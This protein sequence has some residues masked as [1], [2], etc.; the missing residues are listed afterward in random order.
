MNRR[1][2][3]GLEKPG[4]GSSEE[5]EKTT[6]NMSMNR[7]RR[8]NGLE[9]EAAKSKLTWSLTAYD[10]KAVCVAAVE[11]DSM[12]NYPSASGVGIG[13]FQEIGPLD[14]NLKPCNSTWLQKADLLFVVSF[15]ADLIPPSTTCSSSIN[16]MGITQ[17][18]PVGTGFSF[19]EEESLLAKSDWEAA[20]D[21]TAL[22]KKLYNGNTTMQQRN[23]PLF[24]VAESYG[25]RFAVTT[26]L[27]VLH[28]IRAGKLKLKL[29]GIQNVSRSG[30]QVGSWSDLQLNAGSGLQIVFLSGIQNVSRSGLQVSKSD[31]VRPS[32]QFLVRSPDQVLLTFSLTAV[33]RS[34]LTASLVALLGTYHSRFAVARSA[35]TVSLAALLGTYHSRFAVARSALIASLTIL[36]GT[37]R[38]RFAQRCYSIGTRRCTRRSVRPSL[39]S[40]Y[41]SF[42][43]TLILSRSLIAVV[44][45]VLT[46]HLPICRAL[47]IFASLA[48]LLGTQHSF[49]AYDRAGVALGNSWM[50]PEDYVLSWGPLLQDMSRLDAKDAEKSNSMARVIKEEIDNG[51]LA[52]ATN[53]WRVLKYFISAR[54]N[55]V[56][57]HNFLLDDGMD[58]ITQMLTTKTYS[59]YL[60]SQSSTS[61][62]LP[63]FMNG[64]IREK[65]KIIPEHVKWQERS[66][67]VFDYFSNGFMQ[68]RIKEELLWLSTT[69]RDHSFHAQVDLICSNKG[70]HAWLQKLKWKGLKKFTNTPRSP[71]YCNSEEAGVTKGF[72]KS[73]QNLQFYWILRAGHFVRISTT[74]QQKFLQKSKQKSS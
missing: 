43:L 61:V 7:T 74:R 29:G 47:I 70:T 20:V 21:L 24:V 39:H 67:L 62:D 60:S 34:A 37:H 56:S 65:L 42:C 27:S 41:S 14:T 73:Y 33:A 48:A 52:N 57:F 71:L 40:L 4:A 19:V 63:R 45:L 15:H 36:L 23:N 69:D 9:H 30:L 5:E 46:A 13:N 72:F 6:K 59:S 16:E 38:S 11:L 58:P 12:A 22:L 51:E 35:L 3:I 66:D 17:E 53:T 64:V 25:G 2:Q 50:S 54:S 31:M 8:R 28:V 10:P 49:P 55:R 1:T 18:N 32:D 26:T 68:P 44:R